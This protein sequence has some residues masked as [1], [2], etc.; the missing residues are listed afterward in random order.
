MK[1][2]EIITETDYVKYISEEPKFVETSKGKEYRYIKKSILQKELLELY[3][4]YVK[5]KMLRETVTKEGVWGTGVLK[6]RHPV[7]NT[8]L[9]FTGTAS[10]NHDEG[11]RYNFPSLESNCMVN[12]CKKIGIRFGQTLNVD[13]ED[14]EGGSP[15]IKPKDKTVKGRLQPDTNIMKKFMAAVEKGD[16]AAI[17]MIT[18]AY[19]IRYEGSVPVI[20]EDAKKK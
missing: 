15:D 1:A 18:N 11:M 19:E 14:G 8:W 3:G 10:K 2:A 7:T 20:Q 16:I 17:S 4:G 13:E 5:W 6:F 9:Y 12:A